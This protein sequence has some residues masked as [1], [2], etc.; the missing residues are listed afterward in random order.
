VTFNALDVAVLFFVVVALASALF[1]PYR[2]IALRELRVTIVEPA[3]FY[4]MLRS[5]NL[6]E[7]A[8]RRIVGSFALGGVAVA[9][10]GLAQYALDVN[11]IT[12]EQG[13][14]RLR[15]VYGSPNNAALYLGR[16]LPV[17][18]AVALFARIRWRRLLYGLGAVA[19]GLAILLS[20]SRGAIVLGVPLS[21]LAMGVLAG[22]R[23]RW[24][25]VGVV[26]LVA[27]GLIPLMRTPRFARM[28]DPSEGTLFFR[29][30]L[31]RASW[32]MVRD[33]VWLGVGPDNFLYQYRGRY[34]LP[35][36]WQE[37]HL[38]HAHN[39]VLSYA[40]RLGL[41]GLAA[42]AWLQVSFWR[43]ALPLCQRHDF[44]SRA[45]MLGL[46]GLMVSFLGHGLV[47]ASYFFPD[48]AYAFFLALSLVQWGQCK[49]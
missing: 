38:S 36:A 37:P 21:L 45:L 15:S 28:L 9:L 3:L 31:W 14:R 26:A 40:T 33:H 22:G 27:I 43:L 24:A 5:T 48:L 4:L 11:I 10:I 1:A 8:I 18:V 25:S 44:K 19:V 39:V 12:A 41:L 20:F 35:N 34:I 17:L 23:W 30:H 16:V 13:F 47:D 49:T 6:N 46:A 7:K 42:G 29:L 2:H 32:K